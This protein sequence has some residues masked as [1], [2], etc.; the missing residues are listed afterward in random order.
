MTMIIAHRGVSAVAPENTQ[1][2]F[3]LAWA[4]DC[5][6]IELDVQVS[7]DGVVVVSH[8]ENI[9]RVSGVERE[10]AQVDWADLKAVDVG[11]W[12]ASQYQGETLPLLADVLANMPTGKTIQVEVKPAVSNLAPVIAV[13]KAARRDVDIWLMSF[14][15][16]LL[17]ALRRALPDLKTLFLLEKASALAV[18][19]VIAKVRE[20]G[21][22][23]AD[24]DYR[25]VDE[26]FVQSFHEAGLVLGVWTVD[27]ASVAKQMVAWGVDMVASN[28][29][30][31]VLS[32]S[33]ETFTKH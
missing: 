17:V 21:F 13:L 10:I 2:A 12:K 30:H 25:A 8:D 23:G 32:S 27:E 4:H 33:F 7:R 19:A 14:D 5:A 20:G 24:V 1:A 28:C 9:R 15:F 6:G 31:T 22:T 11:A 18:Q 29:P 16:A 3:D 26:A